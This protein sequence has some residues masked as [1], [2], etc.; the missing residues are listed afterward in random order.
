MTRRYIVYKGQQ[1][2][3]T[4][5]WVSQEFNGDRAEA[6]RFNPDTTISVNWNE[7]VSSFDNIRSLHD[8]EIA[9]KTAENKYT[10]ENIKL[11]K[12]TTMPANEEVWLLV[13]GKLQLYAK[14][15]EVIKQ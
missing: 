4:V 13:D 1:G 3:T 9:V 6:L 8:F 14:Y 12:T 7:V 2:G 11:S 5:Y 10:Y 15:G